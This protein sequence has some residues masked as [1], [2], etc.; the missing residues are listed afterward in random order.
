MLQC[1]SESLKNNRAIVLAAVRQDGWALQHASESLKDDEEI[2]LAAVRQN[3]YVLQCASE[4]LKDDGEIVLAAVR[5][6][7][8]AFKYASKRLKND[9]DVIL[10]ALTAKYT[11]ITYDIVMQNLNLNANDLLIKLFDAFGR[12]HTKLNSDY[13][14]CAN[15]SDANNRNIK[16]VA[17]KEQVDKC[18]NLFRDL[19]V[20]DGVDIFQKF[21][22]LGIECNSTNDVNSPLSIC[23][24]HH[25][26]RELDK[27]NLYAS[28]ESSDVNVNE[29]TIKCKLG[30]SN[31][32]GILPKTQQL[33][34]DNLP[35]IN[36]GAIHTIFSNLE[37]R[38][39]ANNKEFLQTI[40]SNTTTTIE[41]LKAHYTTDITNF[42]SDGWLNSFYFKNDNNINIKYKFLKI[43]EYLISLS[44]ESTDGKFSKQEE[45]A[46]FLTQQI[47]FC[48][49]GK[50]TSIT[51]I[52][53]TLPNKEEKFLII[54]LAKQQIVNVTKTLNELM[55]DCDCKKCCIT[56]INRRL[57]INDDELCSFV[58]QI[59]PPDVWGD[60]KGYNITG[61]N[62]DKIEITDFGYE[63]LL[64]AMYKKQFDNDLSSILMNI[65]EDFNKGYLSFVK[66]IDNTINDTQGVHIEKYIRN[67]L[68]CFLLDGK[69]EFD[70]HT[71]VLSHSLINLPHEQLFK[72]FS[73]Y[74]S[75]SFLLEKII[76]K[77][78]DKGYDLKRLGGV[79]LTKKD[80]VDVLVKK[81]IFIPGTIEQ[82]QLPIST[83]IS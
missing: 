40:S 45:F 8:Y 48:P 30:Y 28:T 51:S 57:N 83:N 58:E 37:I 24:R 19:N 71:S 62:L 47:K 34:V 56:E 39:N 21:I 13:T 50:E 46:L 36:M 27:T 66:T 68:Y 4:S 76:S 26:F 32:K 73:K 42:K 3:G 17:I 2:V 81:E 69:V 7:G 12:L 35:D 65:I 44:T 20:Y 79:D 53:N 18:I 22:M 54:D 72:K 41:E 60:G 70:H 59:L 10:A 74:F 16:I 31:I 64:E 63:K 6:N 23:G 55:K 75:P 67:F 80:I 33:T 52:Y 14:D 61:E 11:F 43:M 9:P 25:K 78:A 15:E 38:I 82:Q 49:V 77:I 5:Q 1:A 29:Q